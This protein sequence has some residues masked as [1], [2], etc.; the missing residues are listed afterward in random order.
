MLDAE[1]LQRA[2]ALVLIGPVPMGL[3]AIGFVEI[4]RQVRY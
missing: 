3:G 4:P 2:A 1:P